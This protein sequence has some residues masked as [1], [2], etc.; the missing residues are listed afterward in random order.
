MRSSRQE[1]T[2]EKS[3]TKS[4]Q[5]DSSIFSHI[6]AHSSVFRHIE[7]YT[8]IIQVCPETLCNT[9]I[10]ITTVYSQHW[11]IQ[12]KKHIQKPAKLLR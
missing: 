11:H 12:N 9:S 1:N 5:V 6:L 4:I 10:F 2:M 7:A 3:K 8:G